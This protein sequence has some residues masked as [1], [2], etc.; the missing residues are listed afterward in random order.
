MK[1]TTQLYINRLHIHTIKTRLDDKLMSNNNNSNFEF[2]IKN[3]I[4]KVLPFCIL[5]IIKS[6]L[7]Y[8]IKTYEI[9]Q[10]TKLNKKKMIYIIDNMVLSRANNFDNYPYYSNNDEHWGFGASLDEKI[11]LQAINCYYCGNYILHSGD[12]TLF[13]DNIYCKCSI[14]D[15]ILS[16]INS[17]FI[18]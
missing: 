9:I 7:F 11:E 12:Y 16:Y 14:E 17:L 5:D 13:S 2:Q 10:N 6:F 3:G 8:D 15:E 18:H 1:I 4:I